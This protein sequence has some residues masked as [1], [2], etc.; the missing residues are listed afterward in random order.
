LAAGRAAQRNFEVTNV[1][2]KLTLSVKLSVAV[3]PCQAG[4]T[5]AYSPRVAL[6][7]V[8]RGLAAWVDGEPWAIDQLRRS[9]IPKHSA[10][11]S[12][13]QSAL[14]LLARSFHPLAPSRPA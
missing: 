11:D 5:C 14:G 9:G 10:V 1:A 8:D 6:A 3:P 13:D 7:L 2:S 12:T 4:E